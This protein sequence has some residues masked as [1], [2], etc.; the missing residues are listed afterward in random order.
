MKEMN[1]CFT[2]WIF[3]SRISVRDR[4]KSYQNLLV[5]SLEFIHKE[6]TSLKTY[7]SVCN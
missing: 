5:Q 6:K 3:Q 2:E 7:L 1:I 4:I